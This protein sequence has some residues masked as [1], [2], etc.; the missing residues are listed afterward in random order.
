MRKKNSINAV[1]IPGGFGKEESACC[2]LW[3]VRED[4]RLQSEAAA[5]SVKT[6]WAQIKIWFKMR[7]NHLTC[8]F[9]I[10]SKCPWGCGF[11]FLVFGVLLL[12]GRSA[13]QLLLISAHLAPVLRGAELLLRP[14]LCEISDCFITVWRLC[15]CSEAECFLSR[16]LR[17]FKG[18]PSCRK[19]PERVGLV[20]DPPVCFIHQ[21]SRLPAAWRCRKLLLLFKL[22]THVLT[23][24]ISNTSHSNGS[25]IIFKKL[26]SHEVDVVAHFNSFSETL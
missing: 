18:P 11:D 21:L 10:N 7:S 19:Q 16:V 6:L 8:M 23:S 13:G 17:R 9:T 26:K 12:T 5:V 2:F 4:D 14:E 15:L 20:S 1:W 24:N 3:K 22:D 25:L